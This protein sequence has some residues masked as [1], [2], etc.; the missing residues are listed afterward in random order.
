MAI[1]Y[2]VQWRQI[3]K[4]G[5]LAEAARETGFQRR[6]ARKVGPVPFFWALLAS[7]ST[8]SRR[9]LVGLARAASVYAG[10]KITRQGF[11]KRMTEHAVAFL[12]AAYQRLLHQAQGMIHAGLP[13]AY[14]VFR[15]I[16]LIDST[17]LRLADRLAKLYPACRHNVRKAAL[18]IHACM[19]LSRKHVERLRI[20]A[21]R[22]HDRKGMPI[23]RWVLG[24]LLMFDL[25]YFDYGLFQFIRTAGGAFLTRLKGSANGVLVHVRRGCA[26]RHV[27]RNLNGSLYR[28]PVVDVDVQFKEG[29]H[30]V[31]FRV[32]GI[33]DDTAWD[34]H[35]YVT[36]LGA[37]DFPPEEIAELYRLRWQIELLFKEWKSLCRIGQIPSG[38]PAVVLCLVYASLCVALL[39][40]LAMWLA[41][42]HH[43]IPWE[44]MCAPIATQILGSLIG[45]IAL[46]ANHGTVAALR[47]FVS[48]L[49]ETLAVQSILPN[50]TNALL[51]LAGHGK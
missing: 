5:A 6:E 8:E 19:S 27:G 4:S 51:T 21:E 42:R 22:V 1:Q 29:K 7:F 41:S 10:E 24:R 18:K 26:K 36:S 45:S 16:N 40:R 20:T 28:G 31:T 38:K 44:Q 34:Y 39:S 17:T 50:G 11:H 35:W 47:G 15:D 46:T 3:L 37:E 9:T 12:H 14:A 49:L 2:F 48:L 30:A 25:G 43:G 23:G 13:K 32:V 33:R